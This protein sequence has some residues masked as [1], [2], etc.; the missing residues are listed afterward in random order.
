MA[1][2]VWMI[3]VTWLSGSLRSVV[4]P[5]L[6]CIL[7]IS[8]W[9]LLLFLFVCFLGLSCFCHLL[10]LF[11]NEMYLYFKKF[12]KIPSFLPSLVFFYI[13]VFCTAGLLYIFPFS[14]LE[15]WT[16]LGC[17]CLFHLLSGALLYS[18]ICTSSSMIFFFLVI[19]SSTA[20]FSI[21]WTSF[22]G[23]WGTLFARYKLWNFIA[24]CT[25]YS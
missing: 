5:T 4:V 16:L 1:G 19:A 2:S 20:S 13:F 12:L 24:T 21:F 15:S 10:R 25:V 18:A 22:H 17:V 11:L 14:F 6:L 23:F 7:S 9:S 3:T 8:C